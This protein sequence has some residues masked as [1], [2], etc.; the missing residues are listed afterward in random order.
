MAKI[1]YAGSASDFVVATTTVLASPSGT[2]D[3]LKMNPGASL[4]AWNAGESG[5]QITDILLFTGSDTVGSYTTPGGAAPSGVF[6]AESSS[7]FLFWAEDT[8]DEVFV[9]GA[10]LGATTAQRWVARPINDTARLLALEA[11]DPIGSAEKGAALGVAPLDSGGLVD[12]SYLPAAG[13][14]G[15][16]DITSPVGGTESGH[17][18]LSTADMGAVP[19]ARTISPGTA[20]TG[21]GDL[22]ANRTL[23]VVLG[24]SAGQAAEGNHTHGGFTTSPRPIFAQVLSTDAPT[25][26]KTAAAA[27]PYTWVCDGT[28]DEVQ[29]QA[30]LDAAAPRVGASAPYNPGSPA[31]ARSIGMV[32]LGGGRFNIGAAG[33]VMHNATHLNGAGLASTELRAVSCNQTGLIRLSAATDH[34]VHL[35]NFYMQG[36]SGGG[37]TCSAIHFNMT[38]GANTSTY[39]D[40]NPDSDHLIENL[41]IF[42]FDANTARNGIWLQAG[43]GDHNRGNIVRNIQMRGNYANPGGVGIYFNGASDSYIEAC[44]LGGYNVGYQIAGGNTKLI[45]NKSFYSN[46][47]GVWVTSGR[48]L[49]SGHESQDDDTGLFLDGVPATCTGLVVDTSNAS[50]IQVS[51]DRQQI[52]GFNIF[53]RGGGRYATTVKGLWYDGAFTNCAIIGNVENSAI[54]TPI[55]GT[56][57]TGTNMVTVS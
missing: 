40:A 49:I 11:L 20:L 30:A 19:T 2:V 26:W 52:I 23:N 5:S 8:F 39:P 17:V 48:A 29:I 21:G 32:Q 15:V 6:P 56:P 16:I 54:T 50:G 3:V 7:T 33:L 14:S 10:G 46:Q 41:Y 4:E 35:S 31:S 28:N 27:D 37:G 24:T 38:G 34:L 43:S 25:E 51:N 9:V 55:S 18:V 45:G 44:H 13:V 47:Y 53:N 36:N 1:L 42:G 22:T 57:A 12:A